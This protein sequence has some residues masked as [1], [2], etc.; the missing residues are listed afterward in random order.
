MKQIA[1][2]GLSSFG[3]YLAL[4]LSELSCEVLAIDKDEALIDKVKDSVTKAVIAD[5]TDRAVMDELGVVGSDAIVLSLGSDLEASIITAMHLK[6]L[7]AK[8]IIAKV[9]SEEHLRVM[10]LLEVDQIIF[11]ERDTGY[12]L[13]HTLCEKNILEYLDLGSD[14]AVVELAPTPEM[15]GKTL[16]E[17]DFRKRYGCVVMALRERGHSGETIIPEATTAIGEN[18][19]MV[20]MG[21]DVD[22]EK[23]AGKS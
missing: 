20:L 14:Y 7:G 4:R 11:P 17:L 22:L 15:I 9:L 12:Q 2:I 5:A 3:Y 19:V 6:D 18:H 13:A 8:R 23:L 10:R 16:I 21:K 1:V